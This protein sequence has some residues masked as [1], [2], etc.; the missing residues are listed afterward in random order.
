MKKVILVIFSLLLLTACGYDGENTYGAYLGE[1]YEKDDVYVVHP[2]GKFRFCD[3]D[4][5]VTLVI[6]TDDGGRDNLLTNTDY[7]TGIGDATYAC[8]PEGYCVIDEIENTAQIFI[9]DEKPVRSKEKA[10]TYLN[11]YDE[12][13][14]E[15]R[16]Y[17]KEVEEYRADKESY[18]YGQEYIKDLDGKLRPLKKSQEYKAIDCTI[19]ALDAFFEFINKTGGKELNPEWYP[20][21]IGRDHIYICK[22]DGKFNISNAAGIYTLCVHSVR[23][24]QD[25]LLAYVDYYTEDD[26]LYVCSTEGFCVV[27]EVKNTAQIFVRVEERYFS[28]HSTDESGVTYLS[29]FEQFP[30]RAQE[31]FVEMDSFWE[32]KEQRESGLSYTEDSDGIIR[33]FKYSLTNKKFD[34]FFEKV[35]SW[36]KWLPW[37]N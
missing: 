10:V 16:D 1:D 33:P 11:S 23:G 5:V 24:Y 3:Y 14:K 27:D 4:G 18:K 22:P 13:S 28:S 25:A 9:V 2:D 21:G 30:E 29:S 7:L 35:T 34:E 36:T 31:I 19:N 26:K 17:F 32:G 12:F 37:N 8:S 20:F 6:K 15:A